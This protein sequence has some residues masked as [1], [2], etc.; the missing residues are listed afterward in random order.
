[1]K[2][3]EYSQLSASVTLLELVLFVTGFVAR[4]S[5]LRP[6][7]SGGLG[8]RV[9]SRVLHRIFLLSDL[10]QVIVGDGFDPKTEQFRLIS[11]DPLVLKGCG[12]TTEGVTVLGPSIGM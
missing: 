6:S 1:M 9:H 10:I 11:C 12:L 8:V 3:A 4:H 7:S 5:I 2:D